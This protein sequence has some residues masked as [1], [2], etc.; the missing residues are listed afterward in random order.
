MHSSNRCPW[1]VD[2][3]PLADQVLSHLV[4]QRDSG[5]WGGGALLIVLRSRCKSLGVCKTLCTVY[6]LNC[7]HTVHGQLCWSEVRRK[8]K[9]KTAFR[10]SLYLSLSTCAV[11]SLCSRADCALNRK[12]RVTLTL[13]TPR[14][15][16]RLPRLVPSQVNVTQMCNDLDRHPVG[17]LK[18][19]FKDPVHQM[20]SSHCYAPWLPSSAGRHEIEA[21]LL[22]GFKTTAHSPYQSAPETALAPKQYSGDS[23]AVR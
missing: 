9:L 14:C 17:T 19:F 5:H 21:S 3:C 2:Y 10:R 15:R 22:K 13:A 4:P 8:D 12:R 23:K 7:V 20:S 6:M 1:P 16:R 18:C 11:V